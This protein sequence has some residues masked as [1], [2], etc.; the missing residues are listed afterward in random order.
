MDYKEQGKSGSE[1]E[2]EKISDPSENLIIRYLLGN[3]VVP[4]AVADMLS[5]MYLMYIYWYCVLHVRIQFF[6]SQFNVWV[7]SLVDHDIA[8]GEFHALRFVCTP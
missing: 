5:L 8:Q 4:S 6:I 1:T 3:R 7:S 2:A